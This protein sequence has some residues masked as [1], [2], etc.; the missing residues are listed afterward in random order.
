[1]G[2]GVIFREGG[3]FSCAEVAEDARLIPWV[4][5]AVGVD[6]ARADCF[7]AVWRTCDAR[8]PAGAVPAV[9]GVIEVAGRF[10]MPSCI[11]VISR[12]SC[13]AALALVASDGGGGE[14]DAGGL[15]LLDLCS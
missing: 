3:F 2:F 12:G 11:P 13:R 15:F 4:S 8:Y 9:P 10:P 14:D 1:M 7:L 5:A 6:F